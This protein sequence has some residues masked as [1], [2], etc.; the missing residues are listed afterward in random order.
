MV[1]DLAALEEE[2]DGTE[3]DLR[4]RAVTVQSVPIVLEGVSLGPFR[5][6]LEWS[7]YDDLPDYTVIAVDPR[8]P[9][10][11]DAV[12]HPHVENSQLCEGDGKS[13]IREALQGGRLLDLFLLVRQI[14]QTYNRSSA[15]VTLSEWDGRYCSDCGGSVCDDEALHCQNC[16]S[17]L[18]GECCLGCS[19]CCEDFCDGCLARCGDCEQ[20][21]CRAC[22]NHC[23]DC[24]GVRCAECLTE[25]GCCAD[26]RSA[27]ENDPEPATCRP[28]AATAEAPQ[29]AAAVQSIAHAPVQSNRLGEAPVPA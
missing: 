24:K 25:E 28:A 8:Y 29:A 15:Y 2:F 7:R 19:T 1:R 16:E 27:D 12:T 6:R 10:G 11:D 5:I 26:C 17:L 9:A 13:A 20:S 23:P 14:L 18:C 21:L 3:I 22:L 4:R